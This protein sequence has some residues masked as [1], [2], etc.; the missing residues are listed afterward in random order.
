[1]FNSLLKAAFAVVDIPVALVAD[2]ITLGGLTTDKDNSYT[3]DASK[4]LMK[5]VKDITK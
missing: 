3:T 4:R 1:M 5:N 2:T